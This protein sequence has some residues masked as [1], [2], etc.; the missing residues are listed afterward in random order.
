MNT[1]KKKIVYLWSSIC[2]VM[3]FT[4][5]LLSKNCVRLFVIALSCGDARNLIKSVWPYGMEG[6]Y[7]PKAFT[8]PYMSSNGAYRAFWGM[9]TAD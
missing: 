9:R 8:A 2:I 1:C 3:V 5:F 4:Y 6:W 7:F